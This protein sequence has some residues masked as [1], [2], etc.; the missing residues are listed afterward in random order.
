MWQLWKTNEEESE[1]KDHQ[2]SY[3]ESEEKVT[4]LSP[5][6]FSE[7]FFKDGVRI[8]LSLKGSCSARHCISRKQ[9][10]T[11]VV[12]AN[13]MTNWDHRSRSLENIL[14]INCLDERSPTANGVTMYRLIDRDAAMK[15]PKML[16]SS[17]LTGD[18]MPKAYAATRVIPISGNNNTLRVSLNEF[19]LAA[20]AATVGDQE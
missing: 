16:A 19:D 5:I 1:G 12:D 8:K 15:N 2:E 20:N 3:E 13:T 14:F 11:K 6:F 7:C 10:D 4:P 18:I 17:M 9:V